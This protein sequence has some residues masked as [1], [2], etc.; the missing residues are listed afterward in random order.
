MLTLLTASQA[1][2]EG[3]NRASRTLP[4]VEAGRGGTHVA[5]GLLPAGQPFVDLGVTV[6]V[7]RRWFPLVSWWVIS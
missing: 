3:P 6:M 2:T 4:G 1:T 7:T 5:H